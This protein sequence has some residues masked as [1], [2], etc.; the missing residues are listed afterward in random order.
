M[1]RAKIGIGS[2]VIV[3]GGII[4]EVLGFEPVNFAFQVEH[5]IRHRC[6]QIS[7]RVLK[8]FFENSV[9]IGELCIHGIDDDLSKALVSFVLSVQGGNEVVENLAN[10]GE[11]CVHGID[12][13]CVKGFRELC[14]IRKWHRALPKPDLDHFASQNR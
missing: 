7:A 11:L 1:Q 13:P 6:A 3:A 2:I 4:L 5:Q 14:D 10:V 9:A 12:D 8:C